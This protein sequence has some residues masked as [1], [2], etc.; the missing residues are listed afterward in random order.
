MCVWM[1]SALDALL[2]LMSTCHLLPSCH[3]SSDRQTTS[4]F[5]FP[6]ELAARDLAPALKPKISELQLLCK[7]SLQVLEFLILIGFLIIDVHDEGC[8]K[9]KHSGMWLRKWFLNFA[10]HHSLKFRN[11][12]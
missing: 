12:I 6:I 8:D 2:F 5:V 1:H 10:R 11:L 9:N 3:V 7:V 4:I